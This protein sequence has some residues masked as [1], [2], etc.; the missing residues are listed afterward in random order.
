MKKIARFVILFGGL[1]WW[2]ASPAMAQT[3]ESSD[4][5]RLLR[6]LENSTLVFGGIIVL[7]TVVF[8]MYLVNLLM[9]VQMIRLLQEQGL[10]V[11]QQLG[12]SPE[13]SWWQRMYKKLT[14]VVPVAQE[15]D[16]LLNHD[17]DGI[18]ELDNNL[19]PWWL[20]M[21]YI[22]IVFS[23]GYIGYYHY[24]DY[25]LTSAE[26]YEQ[27][28]EY[29]ANAVAA[30]LDRQADQVTE[31]N[32]VALTDEEALATGQTL[33]KAN[34]AV[35]H[36]E[37]GAGQVGPNL[38]DEYWLHGGDISSIFKTI[39]YGV[40][41]K[42]MIAWKT[43]LRPSDIQKISSY[44]LSLQGTNPANPKEPQGEKF[45]AAKVDTDEVQSPASITN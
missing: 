6:L 1:W 33:Y 24:F 45:V 35:C 19:P 25:G 10:E 13:S 11:A 3:A 7:G 12:T 15:Q 42:G 40:P 18:R 26:A 5:G 4:P 32:V 8:I 44:I 21:F 36:M 34:C 23:V 30:Y 31:S 38:T 14:D 28:M 9:K 20:A 37:D 17:Y 43:Q 2:M 16:I 27:E 22:S 41:E 39:K 29:S